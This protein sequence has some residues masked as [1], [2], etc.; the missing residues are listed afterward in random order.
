MALEAQEQTFS[1]Q[2]D[3][4]GTSPHKEDDNQKKKLAVRLLT[5]IPGKTL[6]S[7][8]PWTIKH[9]FQCGRLLAEF[10]EELKV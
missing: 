1:K 10:I 3:D 5:Y 4:D 9:F 2:E 8:R 7:V 6:Y